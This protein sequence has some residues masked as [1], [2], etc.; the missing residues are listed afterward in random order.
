MLRRNKA[1]RY[2]GAADDID[3]QPHPRDVARRAY[4]GAGVDTEIAADE[5]RPRPIG[6]LLGAAR[7]AR[8]LDL[9]DVARDT[10]VPLR[11]LAAIEADDHD[12]LP[13]LPYAIGFVKAFARVVG[14]DPDMA[15]AH[16]RAETNK[17][18]HVPAVPTMSP[19]DERRLPPR[20]VVVASV[21]ALLVVVGLIVAWS[22]GTF[23]RA[24]T[25]A[26]VIAIVPPVAAP[27]ATA[28][29]AATLPAP[30]VATVSGIPATATSMPPPASS[31]GGTVVITA[32]EDAWFK[33]SVFDP[34]A[35]KVVT[36]KTGVLAK[37]ERYVPP[38]TPGLRLW[39]GR[40]GALAITV[41]GRPI[42][43]LGGPVETVKNV[44]LDPA[45][46]RARIVPQIV[47][48]SGRAGPPVG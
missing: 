37:G 32:S 24:S 19:L 4:K 2:D 15:G 8:G 21:V 46:L 45:D 25:T 23:D 38:A 16:F 11:H 36:V 44:S 6:A 47:P 20:S 17:A 9:A 39:T 48:A 3:L 31:A 27:S 1:H 13:A 41:D 7:V 18:A 14:V 12:H 42:P 10:R 35:H 40:A 34:T 30:A 43:A 5:S 33:V 26:P 28:S 29:P 22:A